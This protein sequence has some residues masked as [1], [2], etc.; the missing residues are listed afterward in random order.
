MAATKTNCRTGPRC[1]ERRAGRST[2][3]GVGLMLSKGISRDRRG[4]QPAG[5]AAGAGGCSLFMPQK[6]P[7]ALRRRRSR[8]S[9]NRSRRTRSVRS[10]DHRRRRSVAGHVLHRGHVR[11]HRA[12]VQPRLRRA[13]ECESRRRSLA[14]GR[15][16]RIVLP[17]QFVLPDAAPEGVVLNLAALRLYYFPSPPRVSSA[18]SSPIRSAS[19]WWAGRRR[20]DRPRSSAS[21]RTRCDAARLGSQGTRC[22]RRH[23]AAHRAAGPDN[24]LGAFAMNLG[25]PTYLVHGTNKPAGVGMRASHGCIRL[26]PRYRDIVRDDPD[27]HQGH[28]REPAAALQVAGRQPVRAI[29]PA[30]RGASGSE[31]YRWASASTK[32]S[33][34]RCSRC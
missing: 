4:A 25:W 12:S 33:P 29:L 6:E 11:R 21:A 34:T 17:T 13:G 26:Y 27:R 10:E 32:A 31:K 14:A 16:T 2:H 24:P 23:P 5:H 7:L 1:S 3:N 22:R 15:G 19:A 30:A 28:C 20:R 18:S 9:P 8:H